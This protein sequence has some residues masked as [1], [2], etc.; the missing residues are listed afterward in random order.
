MKIISSD[1]FKNLPPKKPNQHRWILLAVHT[2]PETEVDQGHSPRVGG[3]TLIGFSV[4][5]ADCALERAEALGAPCLATTE[6]ITQADEA[7]G[8]DP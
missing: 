2:I 1:Q 3:D 7:L 6:E 5:C 4:G 8:V